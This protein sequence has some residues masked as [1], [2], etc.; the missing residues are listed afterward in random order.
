MFDAAIAAGQRVYCGPVGIDAWALHLATP[1]PWEAVASVRSSEG[2][3][4]R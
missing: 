1:L 4:D 2:K 3:A